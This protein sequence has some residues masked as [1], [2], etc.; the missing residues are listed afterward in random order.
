MKRSSIAVLLV[1]CFLS[2]SSSATAQFEAL[3]GLASGFSD[4]GISWGPLF[5]I[6]SDV[7]PERH[8]GSRSL[9]W[10]GAEF[11]FEI[12]PPVAGE[13]PPPDYKQHC[14]VERDKATERRITYSVARGDSTR[15]VDSTD[16]YSVKTTCPYKP[17]RLWQLEIG[18][19]YSE[20]SRF[21]ISTAAGSIS[22][23]LRE[24]PSISVYANY[25]RVSGCDTLSTAKRLLRS[26]WDEYFGLHTGVTALVDP[27]LSS[28]SSGADFSGGSPKSV[29]IGG[30]FGLANDLFPVLTIFSEVGYVYRP[31]P[32]ISW[33]QGST[34][35]PPAARTRLDLSSW[36]FGFGLQVRVKDPKK[37]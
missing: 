21:V 6:H 18:I 22:G 9:R 11:L 30:V 12:G 26:C 1:G 25:F 34:A 2:Y 23:L 24:T 31:F 14:K 7:R 32:R 5:P 20:T 10:Y 19:G 37:G 3:A 27:S 36:I 17:D 13:K 35:A 4:V 28:L 29:Q 8:P 15:R 33:S 16:V